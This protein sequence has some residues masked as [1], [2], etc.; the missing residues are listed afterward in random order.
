MSC[1]SVACS[2]FKMLFTF[3]SL[4]VS[5]VY[6]FA[7]FG[8]LLRKWHIFSTSTPPNRP[9]SKTQTLQERSVSPTA[10]SL[11]LA[12]GLQTALNFY[13]LLTGPS[14]VCLCTTARKWKEIPSLLMLSFFNNSN[15]FYSFGAWPLRPITSLSHGYW[16][17][18]WVAWTVCF[19]FLLLWRLFFWLLFVSCVVWTLLKDEYP[20]IRC[21]LSPA[22]LDKQEKHKSQTGKNCSFL[23]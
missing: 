6:L 9:S 20:L 15:V 4:S 7:F 16:L 13:C 5:L 21:F 11:F 22:E 14:D 3:H 23:L 12:I 10:S 18:L 19:C 2:L 8:F 17:R 1:H